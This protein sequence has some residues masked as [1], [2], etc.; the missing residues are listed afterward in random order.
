[1][2]IPSPLGLLSAS[3]AVSKGYR[4]LFLLYLHKIIWLGKI[5]LEIYLTLTKSI[6]NRHI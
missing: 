6:V 5:I 1:M 3:A 4:C 2:S